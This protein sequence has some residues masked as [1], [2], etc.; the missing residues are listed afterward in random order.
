MTDPKSTTDD[1][2]VSKTGQYGYRRRQWGGTTS[3]WNSLE[4][5]SATA[6]LVSG[7]LFVIFAGLW[8]AFA[9]T[10]MTS[11]VLQ[12]V[13]G[14]AGWTAAFIGLLGLYPSLA[15]R[16]VWL[17]RAGGVFAALGTLGASIST[18]A[19]FVQLIGDVGEPP[20]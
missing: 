5:R 7:G 1:S 9:F 4:G 17:S 2:G 11:R 10:D 16:T 14:P 8:G 13:V 12:D 3:L 18:V 20:A 19:N 6:F 15:D